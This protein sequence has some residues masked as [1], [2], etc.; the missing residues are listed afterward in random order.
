MKNNELASNLSEGHRKEITKQIA[1]KA[2]LKNELK[3]QG[4]GSLGQAIV[5]EAGCGHGHWLTGF[6]QANPE[7][8]SVGIDLIAGRIGKAIAKKEKRSLTNVYF[9]KAELL[10]F[11][12]VLPENV[13]FSNVVF[14][15][16]DPWPKARHHKKRMIQ[17]SF[18][19]RIANRMVEK[20]RCFFRTDDRSYFEW[21]CE[22]L[23]QSE[24]WEIDSQAEWLYE[25]E[26]YFQNLMEAYFSV[27]AQV[28]I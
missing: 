26:T 12:E 7:C 11:L 10:E 24:Y 4:F 28:K 22:H 18:L 2:A 27:T 8:V 23:Q 25:E 5:F 15:F 6:S 17:H 13:K 21:T 9:F 1:R 14:L 20:G 16:P 3:E 19:K